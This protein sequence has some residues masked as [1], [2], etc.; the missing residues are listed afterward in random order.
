MIQRNR[1][2]PS[3]AYRNICMTCVGGPQAGICSGS[4]FQMPRQVRDVRRGSASCASPTMSPSAPVSRVFCA[5]GWP[6]IWKT[7]QPGLPIIP[8]SRLMLLTWQAV[9]VAWWDW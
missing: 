4:T 1:I 5:V 7:L 2:E 8:R 9:A 3:S 6:F